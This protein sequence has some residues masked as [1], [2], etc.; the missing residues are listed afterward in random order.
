MI[1]IEMT[2]NRIEDMIV[3]EMIRN[4]LIAKVARTLL[5]LE[6]QEA[7]YQCDYLADCVLKL[8]DSLNTIMPVLRRTGAIDVD[9]LHNVCGAIKDLH[10]ILSV[11][12]TTDEIHIVSG[13]QPTDYQL[14]EHY[15]NRVAKLCERNVVS[16]WDDN[17][18]CKS[19]ILSAAMLCLSSLIDC[20]NFIKDAFIERQV[21]LQDIHS[22]YSRR[23]AGLV[24]ILD[25]FEEHVE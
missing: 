23:R 2:E 6:N 13:D 22:Y 20:V 8:H 16:D 1:V 19:D 25:E 7:L 4:K 24:R 12:Y 9:A 11:I 14:L 5:V 10:S 15:L 21:Y 18:P 3:I 17:N